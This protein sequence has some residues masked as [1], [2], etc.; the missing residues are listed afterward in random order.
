VTI[1]ELI[2]L[3]EHHGSAEVAAVEKLKV[4]TDRYPYCQLSQVLLASSLNK[5]NSD[6][7]NPAIRRAVAYVPDRA[8]FKRFIEFKP[9]EERTTPESLHDQI[10][11]QDKTE[12]SGVEI[13]EP[14]TEKIKHEDVV[15]TVQD[16]VV[17]QKYPVRL[18]D[19]ET[20]KPVEEESKP[21]VATEE[22]LERKELMDDLA[23]NMANF[24]KYKE[25][26][27]MES[28]EEETV[29]PLTDLNKDGRQEEPLNQSEASEEHKPVNNIPEYHPPVAEENAS[30]IKETSVIEPLENQSEEN[31]D[32]SS[33]L[34]SYLNNL[35]S[36]KNREPVNELDKKKIQD[37]IL[38]KFLSAD[39][40]I[41][42]V[43]P[44]D[45]KE[46][47][48][49]LS[50]PSTH[51]DENLV[52]ENLAEI[53]VKQGKIDKAIE[54]YKKLIWKYPQKRSYFA[55]RIEEIKKL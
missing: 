53:L 24:R 37:E 46:N 8:A 17:M 12:I 36:N 26:G 22:E 15:L 52:S 39:I 48:E 2:V 41:K 50:E 49:D 51:E 11:Y 25:Q 33:L 27:L 16:E 21:A 18:D 29:K 35:E 44:K 5:I 43:I 32:E 45:S 19:S 1:T 23:I 31:Q 3:I 7:K 34:L 55:D 6:E 9:V 20:I 13:K 47:D 30:E 38:E 28:D 4:L 40:A 10:S 42:P 14:E 54:I